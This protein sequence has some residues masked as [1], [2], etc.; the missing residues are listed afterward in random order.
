MGLFLPQN[1]ITYARRFPNSYFAGGFVA[2]PY[3]T[4]PAISSRWSARLPEPVY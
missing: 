3:A 2:H 4:I 1:G